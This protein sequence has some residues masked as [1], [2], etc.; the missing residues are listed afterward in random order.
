MIVHC[1]GLGKTMVVVAEMPQAVGPRPWQCDRS[2]IGGMDHAWY[3][4]YF[5]G[6]ILSILC[7]LSVL[8]HLACYLYG[9]GWL[10]FT[11]L[12]WFLIYFVLAV[13]K[14]LHWKAR[15]R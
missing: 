10:C 3:L 2:L 5:C 14:L 13:L 11:D 7:L 1:C 9:I 15:T 8:R 4:V 6:Q 12:V